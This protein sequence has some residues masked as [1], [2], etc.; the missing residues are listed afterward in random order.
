MPSTRTAHP[1]PRKSA[2]RVASLPAGPVPFQGQGH[3]ARAPG[4]RAGRNSLTMAELREISIDEFAAWLRTQTSP[5]T[6][7]PYEEKT[8]S[9]YCQAAGPCMPG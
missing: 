1:G 2:L 6:K 4:R 9:L 3:L 5:K 7:R 8:V